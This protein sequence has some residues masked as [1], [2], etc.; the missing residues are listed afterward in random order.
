M[1]KLGSAFFWLVYLRGVVMEKGIYPKVS[2]HSRG[3]E[4]PCPNSGWP[5]SC[6]PCWAVSRPCVSAVVIRNFAQS[7]RSQSYLPGITVV[8]MPWWLMET[9]A[10]WKSGG[11]VCAGAGQ[12]SS[13]SI[14]CS[15]ASTGSAPPTLCAW[16]T[17]EKRWGN[18]GKTLKKALTLLFA[19]YLLILSSEGRRA[20]SQSPWSLITSLDFLRFPQLLALG[21]LQRVRENNYSLFYQLSQFIKLE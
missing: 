4:L 3:T 11:F 8:F 6:L 10:S 21:H 7:S 17:H 16:E 20:W 18:G 15:L 13:Q 9:T 5:F 1:Q 19:D 2:S 14:D 12:L